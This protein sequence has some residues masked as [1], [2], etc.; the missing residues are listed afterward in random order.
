[1]C[2]LEDLEE[3]PAR[4]MHGVTSS[5]RL[6]L[7]STCKDLRKPELR[8]LSRIPVLP[9]ISFSGPYAPLL[10][11]FKR[12]K[13]PYRSL[14]QHG[15]VKTQ[16]SMSC[17]PGGSMVVKREENGGI[18]T[19]R[20]LEWVDTSVDFLGPMKANRRKVLLINDGDRA[21]LSLSILELFERNN[22]IVY[23]LPAH[24]PRK[25]QPFDVVLLSVFKNHFRMLSVVALHRERS[26]LWRI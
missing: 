14:L 6:I 15:C 10:F 8:G 26:D 23:V 2:N 12:K 13:L 16:T 7:R 25:T 1:M 11:V 3:T 19:T 21:H 17:L 9:I 5:K 20:F 22:V 4:D 18:Y 24:T